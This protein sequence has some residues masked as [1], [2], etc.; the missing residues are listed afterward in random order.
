MY[1]SLTT[2]EKKEHG[3]LDVV[4]P[5][6]PIAELK[7]IEIVDRHHTTSRVCTTEQTNVGDESDVCHRASECSGDE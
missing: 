4:D 2:Q 3:E 6:H 1:Q 7:P 5:Q